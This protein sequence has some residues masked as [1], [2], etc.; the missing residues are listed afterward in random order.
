[1]ADLRQ[2]GGPAGAADSPRPPPPPRRADAARRAVAPTRRARPPSRL[3][4]LRTAPTTHT[5]PPASPRCD[6]HTIAPHPPGAAALPAG[7]ISLPASVPHWLLASWPAPRDHA[8]G[9]IR[10]PPPACL[11]PG[12]R[13]LSIEGPGCPLLRGPGG[14]LVE[15]L[16]SNE[17]RAQ[18][19]TA[20]RAARVLGRRVNG[21]AEC[22]SSVRWHPPR[23]H[24]ASQRPE[25]A[26]KYSAEHKKWG[27][28]STQC[29]APSCS[30][31]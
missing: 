8:A 19:P 20:V 11:P 21:A 15:V 22:Q 29:V 5:P 2:A 6:L 25:A 16:A 23:R 1:M 28:Y 4:H 31:P 27:W 30:I 3:V 14:R 12:G 24:P 7:G 18:K 9:P 10:R 13:W 17:A 26:G